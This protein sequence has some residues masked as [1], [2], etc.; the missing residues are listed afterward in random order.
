MK[1][2]NTISLLSSILLFFASCGSNVCEETIE[3]L[4]LTEN[5]SVGISLGDQV[6]V[7]AEKIGNVD[8]AK[9][10]GYWVNEINEKRFFDGVKAHVIATFPRLWLTGEYEGT[11][12]WQDDY[13]GDYGVSRLMLSV[14]CDRDSNEDLDGK[15]V[16]LY[17]AICKHYRKH[18]IVKESDDTSTLFQIESPNMSTEETRENL[19]FVA[20]DVDNN[21]VVIIIDKK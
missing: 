6:S 15:R 8:P 20:Q 21:S 7:V 10:S 9:Y 5:G 1:K 16:E 2:V 12:I 13:T 18:H 14:S 3:K 19:I 11:Y 4:A 17:E